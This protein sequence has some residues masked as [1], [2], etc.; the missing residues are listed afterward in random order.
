MRKLSPNPRFY[1]KSTFFTRTCTVPAPL[2]GESLMY[3]LIDGLRLNLFQCALRRTEIQMKE[4]DEEITKLR[5]SVR[6]YESLVEEYRVQVKWH[7]LYTNLFTIPQ[8]DV[9]K[10]Q[11][12]L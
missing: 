10:L 9:C 1:P 7:H 12:K 5:K 4:S 11:L 6:Q 8:I 3:G 2:L